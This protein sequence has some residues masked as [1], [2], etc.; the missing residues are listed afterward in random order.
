MLSVLADRTYRHLFLAQIVALLGT[1]MATIALGLLAY[2][3]AGD[4]A[5][6]ILGTVFTIKMVAYVGIAPIAG[7]FASRWPRRAMLVSLDLIRAVVALCLPFVT[8]IW[9]VYI[10]IFALQSASAAFTP[11]FQATIPDILPQEDRYTRALSLSRL[12]YDLENLISPTLAAIL[13]AFV[14]YQVLFYGTVI[15][16]IGSALLVVSVLLPSPQPTAPRGIY[17]R[18]TRGLRIYLATPRLRGLLSLNLAAA[19]AGAMVLVNTVILVKSDLGL[20]DTQVAMALGAFGGGS[21]LAALILPRL[22]DNRPDRPVMIAGASSL[23]VVLLALG[24][25]IA[26]SGPVWIVLLIGWLAIGVGYSVVLTP[27]GRLLKR[28][29]HPEDRPAVYAAQFAL[30]HACWLLTYPLSGWLITAFGPVVA[31]MVLAMIAGAGLLGGMLLWPKEQDASV[32]HSH[33]DLPLDHPHLRGPAMHSHPIVID[34]YH[35]HWPRAG[36]AHS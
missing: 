28:S 8:E 14:S 12:A 9:Q 2:D 15:G 19:A 3:L 4:R 22:L 25:W 31:F 34:D 20:G 7:A 5:A 26:V 21:M 32:A 36:G 6:L 10:L 33:D 17:D 13:L 30:S 18:T 29:A 11:T 27:S 24:L 35:P 16:F 1:G 23:V